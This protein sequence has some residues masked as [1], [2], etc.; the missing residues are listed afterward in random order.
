MLINPGF[1]EGQK[2]WSKFGGEFTISNGTRRGGV[3]AA[4]LTSGTDSTK[5][6][7]QV[8][9]IDPTSA[10]EFSGYLRPQGNVKSAYL[11]ISWYASFDGSGAAIATDDSTLKLTGPTNEFV[12][13]TTGPV[14]PPPFARSVRVKPMLG[15]V[16][17]APAMLFMDDFAFVPA[18]PAAALLKQPTLDADEEM[19]DLGEE[20]EPTP[21]PRTTPQPTRTPRPAAVQVSEPKQTPD[22]TARGSTM[23]TRPQA[24]SLNS[25]GVPT[26]EPEATEVIFLEQAPTVIQTNNYGWLAGAILVTGVLVTSGLFGLTFRERILAWLDSKR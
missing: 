15:P 17:S 14:A 5:Y 20:P 26:D 21:R 23:R 16:A 9:V 1:E 12:Y 24:P 3:L 18:G 22:T 2:A 13:L 25:D 11:R 8:V 19:S 7:Y 6:L 10:Y 4:Q